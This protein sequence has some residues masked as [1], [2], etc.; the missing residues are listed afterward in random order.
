MTVWL[1]S[2]TLLMG[3][4]GQSLAL[5]V[6]DKAP[7][8]SLPATTAEKIELANYQGKQPV[9]LFFYIGAFTNTWT[10]EALAFQLDLPKFEALNAQV[11][12]VSVDFNDANKTWAEKLGL[13]YPLLSDLRRSMSRDYGVLYDDPAMAND[14]QKI[15]LYLRAKRAWFVIDKQGVVRYAKTTEPRTLVPNDEILQVLRD[16][17]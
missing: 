2:A 14:P 10:Q 4:A 11:L 17:K 6:G 12:G 15:P 3:A 9:V 13:S 8:F 7:A 1:V 5:Q 16:L